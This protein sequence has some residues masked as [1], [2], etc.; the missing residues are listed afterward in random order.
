M[1]LCEIPKPFLFVITNED[2]R[3]L[4]RMVSIA[5]T[6]YGHSA[7]LFLGSKNS[8]SLGDVYL[9]PVFVSLIR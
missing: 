8:L 9:P 5:Y 7:V 2:K 6:H 4:A 1:S 3:S